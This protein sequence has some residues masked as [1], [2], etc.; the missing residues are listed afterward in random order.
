MN[1]RKANDRFSRQ[2][3]KILRHSAIKEKYQ[4]DSRGF[5]KVNDI[6]IK[7]KPHTHD[8]IVAIVK[9]DSK[10]R[11]VLEC[12]DET[13]YIR[14]AQGHTIPNIDPD[15]EL[16]TDADDLPVVVHGTNLEAF[17]QIKVSGLNKMSRN[18]IHFAHGTFDDVT[19][20][21][22]MR[23]TAKVMIYINVPKAMA[24]GITFYVSSNEVILSEGIDGVIAPEYFEKVVVVV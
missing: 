24:D 3:T 21:S 5:V 4:M 18:H 11:F 8:D 17:E 1:S 15:L 20:T 12:R 22:G 7:N 10:T 14:A 13:W 6:L 9:A 23:R 2:L 16:I 19:V